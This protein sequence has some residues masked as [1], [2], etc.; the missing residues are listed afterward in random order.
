MNRQEDLIRA[1]TPTKYQ[2][3]KDVEIINDLAGEIMKLINEFGYTCSSTNRASLVY[4]PTSDDYDIEVMISVSP[5]RDISIDVDNLP[6][7][8]LNPE[9]QT[10]N[11]DPTKNSRGIEQLLK[12]VK[13]HLSQGDKKEI[14][15][16][17]R[18]SLDV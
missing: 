6:Y 18:E 13:K 4:I 10:A 17:S 9:N 5:T 1:I 3:A 15:T 11:F 16:S 2:N 12:R 14:Q 7:L 8:S